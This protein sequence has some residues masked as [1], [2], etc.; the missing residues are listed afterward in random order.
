MAWGEIWSWQAAN[1]QDGELAAEQALDIG[2]FNPDYEL[3]RA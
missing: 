3:F 2:K 1:A